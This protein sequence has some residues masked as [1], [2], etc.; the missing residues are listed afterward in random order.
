MDCFDITDS[1]NVRVVCNR[2]GLPD[3]ICAWMTEEAAEE[4]AEELGGQGVYESV[5]L[6]Y[7]KD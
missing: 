7:R 2:P 5:R 3:E 1:R 4:F 6:E